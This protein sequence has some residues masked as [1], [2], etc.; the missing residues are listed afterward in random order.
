[1]SSL[2]LCTVLCRCVIVASG[3]GSPFEFGDTAVNSASVV[4]FKTTSRSSPRSCQFVGCDLKAHETRERR[5]RHIEH[6]LFECLS[7]S[8]LDSCM[9]I[10]LLRDDLRLLRVFLDP[11]RPSR[12][13]SRRSLI[14]SPLR[15]ARLVLPRSSLTLLPPLSVSQQSAWN[16]SVWILSRLSCSVCPRLYS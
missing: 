7:V 8:S 10:A 12:C 2:R 4:F 6:L 1:M 3:R 9:A 16:C 13:C 15:L 5:R 14:M 11:I